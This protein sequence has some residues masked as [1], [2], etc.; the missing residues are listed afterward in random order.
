MPIRKVISRSIGTDVILAEDIA[1]NAITVSEL[2]NGAV[3]PAKLS[4]GGPFWDTS[5]NFGLGS[6]NT[7]PD[8]PVHLKSSNNRNYFRAETTTNAITHEAGF[9][10]KTPASSFLIGSHG[11]TNALWIYDAT[12][13][14]ERLRIDNQGNVLIG[15][16]TTARNRLTVQGTVFSTPT[17]GTASGQAFFGEASGYGMM[18]GTSGFG[19][20]WI[21]QQRVDSA[22][23]PYALMLNPVGGTVSANTTVTAPTSATGLVVGGG[24][25]HRPSYGSALSA[26]GN[27]MFNLFTHCGNSTFRAGTIRVL[28]TENQVNQSYAEYDF[29][30]ARYVW[31][32]S[33]FITYHVRL[34]QRKRATLNNGYGEVYL[35]LSNYSGSWTTAD[36]SAVSGSNTVN[37]STSIFDVFAR[38]AVGQA[39]SA[40][41]SVEFMDV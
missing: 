20:G 41:I 16:T 11:N 6:G 27:F 33:G 30:M 21:Q 31:D 2:S 17:L 19:Y 3:T 14:A 29:V 15:G 10:V 35:Y 7:T 36:Q 23:T 24:T 32:G 28:G 18:L 39:C 26:G 1:A 13:A 22:A 25:W 4:T 12:G 9:D 38:N 37:G 5:S 40:S 8:R 34:I